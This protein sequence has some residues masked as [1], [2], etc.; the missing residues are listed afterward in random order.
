MKY[1]KLKWPKKSKRKLKLN[2][3]IF[4][5]ESRKYE[6]MWTRNTRGLIPNLQIPWKV[7]PNMEYPKNLWCFTKRVQNY[8]AQPGARFRHIPY[9]LH[10]FIGLKNW[11]IEVVNTFLVLF[12]FIEVQKKGSRN[13]LNKHLLKIER[14]APFSRGK[15]K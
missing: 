12:L 2:Y 1:E 11:A 15:T 3:A 9:S 14:G 13:D 4:C 6:E 7:G 8:Q 10:A 5:P